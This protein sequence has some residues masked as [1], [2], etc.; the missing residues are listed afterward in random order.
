M[1]LL[2][3]IIAR[4]LNNMS[5]LCYNVIYVSVITL[6]N[7]FNRKTWNLYFSPISN[8]QLR[9]LIPPSSERSK[10]TEYRPRTPSK[11]KTQN[12]PPPHHCP[13]PTPL[14]QIHPTTTISISA[15]VY[16]D[17]IRCVLLTRKKCWSLDALDYF[18]FTHCILLTEEANKVI[19]IQIYR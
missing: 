2:T 9:Y 4:D 16:D 6:S 12:C 11:W 7:R 19:Y 17:S 14:E 15:H 13:H 1:L 18:W 5:L 10:I 8:G 3:F